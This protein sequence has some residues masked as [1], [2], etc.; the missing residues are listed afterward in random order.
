MNPDDFEGTLVLEKLS[1]VGKVDDFIDAV[2]ADDFEA[3]RSLMKAAQ[4]DL[5]T[6]EIVLEKMAEGDGEH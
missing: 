4:V 6:M 3:A 2:D 1:A 5:E